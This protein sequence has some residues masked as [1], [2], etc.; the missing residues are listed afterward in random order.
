MPKPE[1]SNRTQTLLGSIVTA[2]ITYRDHFV[3]S[4]CE[5][6]S[7]EICMFRRA[8]QIRWPL[9]IPERD[10]LNINSNIVELSQKWDLGPR[11][12]RDIARR[13]Y[14]CA[15]RDTGIKL[16]LRDIALWRDYAEINC[17]N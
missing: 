13:M 10:A 14:S 12:I 15:R 8:A 5:W 16:L 3:I 17:P 6:Y 11:V 4:S 7:F 9:R 2:M 1:I